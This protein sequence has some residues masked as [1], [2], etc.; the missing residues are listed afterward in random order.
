[1]PCEYWGSK[2]P[3]DDPRREKA[4]HVRVAPNND[5]VAC[6]LEAIAVEEFKFPGVSIKHLIFDNGADPWFI[7]AFQGDPST[8]Y[9]SPNSRWGFT[10]DSAYDG[11]TYDF[12]HGETG[13][14]V[15][16]QILSD[17]TGTNAYLKLKSVRDGVD[18]SDASNLVVYSDYATYPIADFQTKSFK[19]ELSG[20]TARVLYDDAPIVVGGVTDGDGYV[21]YTG[22][23]PLPAGA[24]SSPTFWAQLDDNYD[25]RASFLMFSNVALYAGAQT[26]ELIDQCAPFVDPYRIK[27][28]L[29][30]THTMGMR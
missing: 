6:R 28:Y 7:W 17:T 25:D 20:T 30:N 4:Y 26:Y 8:Q 9:P 12:H 5:I 1:M 29:N 22:S 14:R 3:L 15:F 11:N 24:L 21:T 27:N 18:D 16:L 10:D 19:V 2:Y 13:N 23:S